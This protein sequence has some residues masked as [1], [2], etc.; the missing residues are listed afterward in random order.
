[1]V[2]DAKDVDS[3]RIKT[4]RGCGYTHSTNGDK[5]A[6]DRYRSAKEASIAGEPG[7]G[8]R[9]A[10]Q[11]EGVGE[12]APAVRRAKDEGLVCT[13]TRPLNKGSQWPNK[14]RLLLNFCV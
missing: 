5:I 7:A 3:A 13:A 8:I 11:I 9:I 1:M 14:E 12:G 10:G 2:C 6:R 4:A